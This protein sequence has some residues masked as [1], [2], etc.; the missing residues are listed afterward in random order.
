MWH[1]SICA[2]HHC[3]SVNIALWAGSPRYISFY[4]SP[5]SLSCP[6]VVCFTG[7]RQCYSGG[8]PRFTSYRADGQLSDASNG[9]NCYQLLLWNRIQDLAWVARLKGSLSFPVIGLKFR[10]KKLNKV[11]LIK[12][13]WDSGKTE[14]RVTC[15]D[16]F[17]LSKLYWFIKK[18]TNWTMMHV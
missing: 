14:K 10:P 1:V 17:L 8:W 15:N 6:V 3:A 7:Q 5:L 11:K 9:F 18:T 4:L 13:Y 12:N 16:T 2:R